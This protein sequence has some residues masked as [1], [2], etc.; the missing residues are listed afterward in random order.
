MEQVNAIRR[1]F[2]PHDAVRLKQIG[3]AITE[4]PKCFEE[5]LIPD[6]LENAA[7]F[8]ESYR[9]DGI[10]RID[11]VRAVRRNRDLLTLP[12]SEQRDEPTLKTRMK[13]RI[14]FLKAQQLLRVNVA[15]RK[16][17]DRVVGTG[18]QQLKWEPFATEADVERLPIRRYVPQ[19]GL[20]FQQDT[21]IARKRLPPCAQISLI[22]L[23]RRH[24]LE[25]V[26]IPSPLKFHSAVS[27]PARSAR[28][29][30]TSSVSGGRMHH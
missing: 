2:D 24:A 21:Q 4:R 9:H 12:L 20:I 22:E 26:E 14:G 18:T 15:S 13:M 30:G 10:C 23:R 1:A 7:R 3:C 17:H 27:A 29:G 5:S 8:L 19:K 6:R 16:N 28:P 25:L 11:H